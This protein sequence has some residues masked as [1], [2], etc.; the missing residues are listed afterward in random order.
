M[1][2]SQRKK[3]R[4]KKLATESRRLLSEVQSIEDKLSQVDGFISPEEEQKLE[5]EL[6]HARDGM[7]NWIDHGLSET[8]DLMLEELK[9]A[10]ESS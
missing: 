4:L 7:Q 6:G 5:E 2:L 3:A 10:A 9:D 1:P 8:L